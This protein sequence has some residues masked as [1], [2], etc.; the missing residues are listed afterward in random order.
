MSDEGLRWLAARGAD[1]IVYLSCDPATL[2]RD[3]AA[4]AGSVPSIR[5][6]NEWLGRP[7]RWN[8]DKEEFV[9]DPEANRWLDRPYREP[10]SV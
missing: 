5:R 3:V 10:W 8:P 6:L 9:N 7:L 1:R 4:L 2:A